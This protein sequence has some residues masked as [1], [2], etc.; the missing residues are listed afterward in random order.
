MSVKYRTR[1]N[2]FGRF[3]IYIRLV[4]EYL[5]V[6]VGGGGCSGYSYEFDLTDEPLDPEN[7]LTFEKNGARV[8][9]IEKTTWL[10]SFSSIW[11]S[12][13]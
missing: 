7:D 3:N 5:R 6:S 11:I 8:G 2:W 1:S 12:L 10:L 4:S 9:K 13:S